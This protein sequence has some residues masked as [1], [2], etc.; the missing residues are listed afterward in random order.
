V[1][2]GNCCALC[3]SCTM[4]RVNVAQRCI[5]TITSIPS[6]EQQCVP[7]MGHSVS[8]LRNNDPGRAGCLPP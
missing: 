5:P 6:V 8:L 4:V 7:A 2:R 1:I 3:H